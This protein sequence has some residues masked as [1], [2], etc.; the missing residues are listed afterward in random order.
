MGRPS[1]V[2]HV[3][4]NTSLAQF[5]ALIIGSGAG[6]SAAAYV[7]TSAGLNVLVL[8]AGDNNFPGLDDPTPGMPVPRYSN[9][10]LKGPIR[11]FD[12]Q[13]PILEPRTF[14][15]NDTVT[16]Q[17][18]AD[19]N[20]LNRTVGGTTTHADMKYPRFNEVDFHL[21]SALADAGRSFPGTS[22]IDW[23][24]DYDELEPF[25]GMAERVTGVAG[26][27]QGPGSDPFASR[28]SHPYPMPPSP[29]MYIGRVL[30]AGA[31]KAGHNP[32]RYPAAIN[33]RPYP[34]L[35][36]L[37]R[38][39]CVNC[40]FCSGFGC[41]NNSKSSAA[42]TTLRAA[43]LS[44]RCQLRFNSF[45]LR[46][47][48]G[49]G[50]ISGVEYADP[51]GA[52][53]T[54]TADR[55]IL[56]AS[57]MES[58]RLLLLSD[59]VLAAGPAAHLGRHL[60]FHFQTIGVGIFKQRV[61]GDRGQAVTNGLSD[62]RGVN[63]GGTAL[64]PDGRP[65]GGIVEFG[66]SSEPIGAGK[67][68]LQSLDIAESTR[69][70]ITLKDLLVESPFHTH[71]GVMIMQ[72]E[73]APQLTNMVDLD[74]NVRDVFG[75]PAARLTYNNHR[76]E[77]DAAAYYA[78]KLVEIARQ[79]GAQFGFIDPTRG[80]PRTRHVLGGL[81]MGSD[82]LAS[83]CDGFGQVRGF[84]NLYCMDGGVMPTG[85]GYNPTLTLI[86]VA[87]RNAANLVSPGA[88]ERQLAVGPL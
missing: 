60:L 29:E 16:A 20:I 61:H 62:F 75:R 73:D 8:E 7:L 39:P 32:I 71:I 63:E 17:A 42:V 38:P 78:P 79:A 72:A 52:R 83:V 57:A 56:A 70:P 69:S 48:G 10:E 13:D 22:F 12:R 87:L 53:Q 68:A 2:P 36:E 18:D 19:V 6:G 1:S 81:R 84:D 45:A 64:H 9:D 23:P 74:P 25:Y 34:A 76:F 51:T 55:V 35:P 82:P 15:A 67:E 4:G 41:P 21:A 65:L 46:L 54:V 33:S 80:I 43:L 30:S 11:L 28:R 59:L 14:R 86:A 50:H 27:A 58:A 88:A 47:L 5:D 31:R 24:F 3:L 44:D 77:L 85:S 49:N 37:Q 26:V 40:G 66:T